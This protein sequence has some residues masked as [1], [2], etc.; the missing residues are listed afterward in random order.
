MNSKHTSKPNNVEACSEKLQREFCLLHETQGSNMAHTQRQQI[1][2]KHAILFFFQLIPC[3]ELYCLLPL[4]LSK[5]ILRK[6]FQI[7]FVWPSGPFTDMNGSRS[8]FMR[9]T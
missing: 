9:Y 2:V 3:M 4:L 8:H 6:D 1:D 5:K 7:G